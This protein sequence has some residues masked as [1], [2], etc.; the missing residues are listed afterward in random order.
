MKRLLWIIDS[1]SL[2]GAERLAADLFRRGLHPG[3]EVHLVSLRDATAGNEMLENELEGAGL[4]WYRLRARHLRD[5]HAYQRLRR[6]IHH[7]QPDLIH[8]HLRYATLWGSELARRDQIPNVA[9]LH[10]MPDVSGGLRNGLLERLERRALRRNCDAVFAVGGEQAEAWRR[11]GVPATK[12]RLVPNGVTLPPAAPRSRQE[13]LHQ[14]G[15]SLDHIV[16]LTVAVVREPKGWRTLLEAIPRVRTALPQARFIW[17][18]GGPD[19]QSFKA[20]RDRLGLSHELYLAGGRA[21]IERWLEA[22]DVFLFPSEREAQPTALM[23]AMAAGVPIVTTTL[24]AISEVIQGAGLQVPPA[25]PRAF[26]E[27]CVKLLRTPTLRKRFTQAGRQRFLSTYSASAWRDR[28]FAEYE[29]LLQRKPDQVAGRTPA[30]NL[31]L[32]PA[33]IRSRGTG[34]A[35]E[36]AP[37]LATGAPSPIPGSLAASQQSSQAAAPL[38][39]G[40]DLSSPESPGRENSSQSDPHSPESPSTIAPHLPLPMRGGVLRFGNVIPFSSPLSSAAHA[41][42]AQN[43]IAGSNAAELKAEPSTMSCNGNNSGTR[44]GARRTPIRVLMVEMFSHAGLYHYSVQLSAALAHAGGEVILLTGR[45]PEFIPDQVQGRTMLARLLTWNPRAPSRLPAPLRRLMHGLRYTIAC[46]QVVLQTV[47]TRPGWVLLGDF[48]HR[49]DRL[50]VLALQRLCR[51]VRVADIW[52]NVEAF[53]RLHANPG[54][55]TRQ[56]GWRRRLAW[57]LDA[58]FVHGENLRHSFWRGLGRPA[59]AIPHGNQNL[60]LQAASPNDPGLRRRLKIPPRATT[61]LLLGT[62]TKYKGVDVLIEA[63]ALLQEKHRPVIVIAGFPAADFPLNSLQMRAE[64]AGVAPFLRWI[65]SYIPTAEI[66][67]YLRLAD[68][69]VLPYRAASQSGVGH[70]AKAAGLPLLV[71]DCGGLPELVGD[72]QNSRVIPAGDPRALAEA[73]SEWA[74]QP[75]PLAPRHSALT[76]LASGWDEAAQLIYSRLSL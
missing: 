34:Q 30:R 41:R 32:M 29:R 33:A 12:L 19:F 10:V 16:L 14:C 1:L 18:G 49:C 3:W 68:F 52:H 39:A 38:V 13:I 64:Q 70:L 24:P 25:D 8:C 66:A 54:T 62:L 71:T 40:P 6:I 42:A 55:L 31:L 36:L 7:L 65:P 75:P 9:T 51:G 44:A 63:L 15:F 20:E 35:S 11:F 56:P 53:E 23:E 58:V 74:M 72:S 73:L 22:A 57:E 27:G 47:R 43:G 46:A 61:G 48:E 50:L 37:S 59:I 60:L 76:G 5:H 67:W 45:N 2:G 28:L 21:D 69:A 26:A 4:Y 17:V